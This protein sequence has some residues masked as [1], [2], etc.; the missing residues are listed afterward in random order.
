MIKKIISNLSGKGFIRREDGKILPP[1]TARYAKQRGWSGAW[2]GSAEGFQVYVGETL[3]KWGS[4]FPDGL[5]LAYDLLSEVVL[6]PRSAASLLK[7]LTKDTEGA[8]RYDGQDR[9]AG[10]TV[11]E[12]L[13]L[14]ELAG[15]IERDGRDFR[16]TRKGKLRRTHL[17]KRDPYHVVEWIFSSV[18]P[19]ATSIFTQSEKIS[20]A[21]AFMYRQSGG[22]YAGGA[23]RRVHD[24]VF[25]HK[26]HHAVRPAINRERQ[27]EKTRRDAI[28]DEIIRLR[29]DLTENVRFVRSRTKLQRVRDALLRGEYSTAISLLGRSGGAFSRDGLYQLK[30]GGPD[31][32]LGEA[33]EPFRWQA[34]ALEVWGD[35][36]G[37]GVLEVVTGAGKTV[38]A[39][40]AIEDLLQR[41]PD[42]RVSVL[43]PTRVLMYQWATELVRVLGVPPDD[44]GLRGDGHR[45]S[46]AEGRRVILS[47][48]NSAILDDQLRSDV[49]GLP[50]EI[51]HFLIAD[52]CHRYRGAQFRK[53]F[54]ARFDYSLGLSATPVDPEVSASPSSENAVQ[55]VITEALGPV[56]FQY[57]YREALTNRIIQPFVVRYF[58][59]ELTSPERHQ[60]DLYT[61]RI[62][63]AL[64]RIRQRY[65]PRLEAMPGPL[66][67]RLHSILNSDELPDPAIRKFFTAVRERKALVFSARNRKWAYLDIISKHTVRKEEGDP[68]DRIIVFHERIENLE[69]V[70]APKDYRRVLGA[71]E[72][73]DEPPA[74]LHDGGHES[75]AKYES[76]PVA[77]GVDASLESLF[78]KSAFRPV[79][80]HSGHSSPLWNEIAMDWF[81]EGIANVMLSVKAL[82]EGVDVPAANVG[83]VRASSSSV[84]QR[85]QTTGRILRRAVGKDKEAELYVLYVRDT[86]DE[87]IFRGIDWSEQLGNSAVESYHW[88][89]PESSQDTLGRWEDRDGELPD[90]PAEIREEPAPEF[91]VEDLSPGNPYPGKYAGVEYHVDA[92]GRPFKKTRNGR[93]LIANDEV[94][95]GAHMILQLKR[96]GKFVLTSDNHMVTRIDGTLVFVGVLS[97][98]LE[99]EAPSNPLKPTASNR[100]PTFEEL[101]G[102]E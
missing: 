97:E 36:G 102:E 54:E 43:V 101:F 51:P 8:G 73:A 92:N 33:I 62:R 53:A 76:D 90:A 84:R 44:I 60:Y 21:K 17:R 49:D 25:E 2:D 38:F 86:T 89:P 40:M 1:E 52:E 58:G 55:D 59:V 31:Y 15:W 87:R 75:Y 74:G 28:R 12:V 39:F 50:D 79:M 46:F 34:N 42:L 6:K 32:T 96:G 22:K 68:E 27:E 95:L 26:Y 3:L 80:Y 29:P 91:D 5:V 99:L 78:F 4:L 20:L 11:R 94:K 100:P 72:G 13:K 10:R 64:K 41:C 70:I 9:H 98:E 37:K 30:H 81:R 65:G 85:I 35:I 61:K 82:V 24:I 66:Y 56:F 69:E 67:S 16:V 93:R 19:V 57:S 7:S 14:L 23:I 47:V 45:D 71:G 63:K 77:K 48:I 83:I 88:Y 18:D